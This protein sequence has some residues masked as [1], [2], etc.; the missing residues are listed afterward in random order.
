MQITVHDG[1]I[2]QIDRKERSRY[3]YTR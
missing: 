3:D 1:R 2:A